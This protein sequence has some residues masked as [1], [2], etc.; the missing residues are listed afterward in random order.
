MDMNW[1]HEQG[2]DNL[3]NLVKESLNKE[4]IYKFP[5]PEWYKKVEH[6]A[7]MSLMKN[8]IIWIKRNDNLLLYVPFN[9]RQKLLY[10]LHS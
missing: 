10:A 3:S 2:K 4:W 7:N 9:L 5:M 6:I 8:N 1:A